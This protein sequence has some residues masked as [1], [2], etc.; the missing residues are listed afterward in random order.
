M[1]T[2]QLVHIGTFGQPLGL[3]G[4]V[5]IIIHTSSID[6]FKSLSPYTANDGKNI[7][8]FDHLIMNNGKLV[9]K[10]QNC[11][12]RNCAE[13][14][15]GKKIFTHKDNLPKTKKNQ[16]YVSDL[17]NCKAKTLNNKVLGKVIN[18]DNFGAGDLIN[19]QQPNGKNFYIPMNKENVVKIDIKNRLL[20]VNPITGILN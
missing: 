6:S 4:E 5:K 14:L 17:I 12:T 9:G 20:I 11:N 8:N 2:K 18:I 3:K 10:L 7:W 16:F 1:K 15:Y 13:H 19:I